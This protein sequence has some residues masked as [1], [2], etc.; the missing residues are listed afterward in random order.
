M[1]ILN[2]EIDG[3]TCDNCRKRIKQELLNIKEIIDVEIVKNI[4]KITYSMN[5]LM[6]MITN[7]IK[8]IDDEKYLR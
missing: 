2:V 4:A 8:V 5:F 1:N 6:N 3:I 7:N